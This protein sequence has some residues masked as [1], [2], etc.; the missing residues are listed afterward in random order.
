MKIANNAAMLEVTGMGSVNLTL[1]WDDDNLVLVDAGFPEQTDAIV[2]A[3]ADAGF[4]AAQITH[5]II[6]HQDMD[7]IG[8]VV[9]LLKIARSAKVVAHTEETPYID[10][11]KTPIKLAAMLEN[12]DSLP[13][14]RK[15]WCDK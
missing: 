3:I 5:I 13:D 1:T 7:H 10:G 2:Q 6:T 11:S 15:A 4:S 14:D 8:C 12:Y 9:D